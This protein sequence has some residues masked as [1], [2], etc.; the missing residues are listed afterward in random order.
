MGRKRIVIG[1]LA[2]VLSAAGIVYADADVPADDGDLKVSVHGFGRIQLGQVVLGQ[3]GKEIGGTTESLEEKIWTEQCYAGISVEAI[4]KE[5]LRMVVSVEPS[6]DFS[7]PIFN[8]G[9]D[10]ASKF[11]GGNVVMGPTYA[12]IRAIRSPRID[13]DFYCGYFDYKYNPDVR[14]LGEYMFRSSM[15]PI[16]IKTDF[17]YALAKLL[18]LRA[19]VQLMEKSLS[20]DIIFHSE[21]DNF[22]VMDWSLSFLAEYDV[23]KLGFASIGAGVSLHHLISATENRDIDHGSLTTPKGENDP[24][25]NIFIE[26]GDTSYYTFAGTKVMGRLSLDPKAFMSNAEKYFGA[27]DLKLY[28]EAILIGAKAYPDSGEDDGSILAH[29]SFSNPREKTPIT[30]GVNIPTFKALDVLNMEFEY[31]E[32]KY[33][34]DVSHFVIAEAVPR[35]ASL[36][37][38]IE[39]AK[40]KWSVYAKKS[41]FDGHFAVICQAARDHMQLASALF[42]KNYRRDVL[43]EQGHWWW[44]TKME[45]LF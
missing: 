7:Y 4:Y 17:D 10:L 1:W 42:Q 13:L 45:F 2:A 40:W 22:P 15:Y 8:S 19:Q 16:Y 9:N 27:E 11:A 20:T 26:N 21:T 44:A 28:V 23:A 29:M 37:D 33:L 5:K 25:F 14:N 12:N 32:S 31:F 34:N 39:E 36:I 3:A 38:G 41:F 24:Q 35:H 43:I 6:I 30:F 18:G